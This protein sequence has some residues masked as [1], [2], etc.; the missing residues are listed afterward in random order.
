ME[1]IASYCVAVYLSYITISYHSLFALNA[2]S[3]KKT[4]TPRYVLLCLRLEELW[5]AE[6]KKSGTS[7]ASLFRVFVRFIKR[8]WLVASLVLI[9][10]LGLL[11]F[12]VV[13]TS[14]V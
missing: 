6:L 13:R 10:A 2:P 3:H 5:E 12:S 9:I 4:S 7:G 11:L 14:V 8:R 1:V